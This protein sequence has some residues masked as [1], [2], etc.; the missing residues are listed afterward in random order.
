VFEHARRFLSM[1]AV[2]LEMALTVTIATIHSGSC[3]DLQFV[4]IGI[5]EPFSIA[6]T[7]DVCACV[8]AVFI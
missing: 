6:V 8:C 2:R 3:S 4:T 1:R 7:F 5:A